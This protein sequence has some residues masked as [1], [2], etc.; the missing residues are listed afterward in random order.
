[1]RISLTSQVRALALVATGALLGGQAAE[2]ALIMEDG[3]ETANLSKRQNGFSWGESV[4]ASVSG[5]RVK[6]GSYAL[7]FNYAAN[8]SG[9]DGW[10][11]QRFWLGAHYPEIWIRYD[12]YIPSNFVHRQQSDDQENNKGMFY[13][14]SGDYNRPDGP[15]LG[16]EYWPNGSAN[17]TNSYG[18]LRVWAPS[19]GIDKHVWDAM[20]RA[21]EPADLGQWVR[22]VIH[23][24]YASSSNNDGVAEVWKTR[25]GARTKIMDIRNGNWYVSGQRGFDQGYLLGWANSGFSSST[26]FAIDNFAVS[27]TTLLDDKT[28]MPPTDVVA[29]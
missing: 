26:E 20:P 18:T 15:M 10:A 16:N 6:S 7:R 13:L 21:I 8:G 11:E 22:I 23:L 3:F 17:T 9:Q 29:N 4:S 28:P 24:K 5:A 14:W 2:A 1:M 25:G 27:T 19:A 12:L